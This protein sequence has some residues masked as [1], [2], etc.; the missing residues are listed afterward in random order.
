[1][2]KFRFLLA[3]SL[4]V[5][6]AF[7]AA[8]P[9]P[10]L[11]CGSAQVL[12]GV[13][14]TDRGKPSF[15]REWAWRPEHS[16][17][18]PLRLMSNFAGTDECKPVDDG[19]AILITSSGNALALVSRE[20][21]DTLFYATVRNAHSAALLPGGLIVAAAS[22]SSDGSGDR[23]LLFDRKAPDHAIDSFP[24]IG[25]HGVEWD[26]S[27]NVL[28][29]LSDRTLAQIT[30]GNSRKLASQ[31]TFTLPVRGGHDLVL[32]RDHSVLYLTTS[33]EVLTFDPVS[34][35]FSPFPP[36]QGISD[37]K[38]LSINPGTGQ[39]MYTQ[40]EPGVWW[41]YKL[42]FLHPNGEVLLAEHAYKARW[43]PEPR[44]R[45]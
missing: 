30:I 8:Q 13:I 35:K 14:K 43:L 44:G 7:A 29:A 40:A 17:G 24:F 6:S 12:E 20:S 19:R 25:A 16:S 9:M 26:S 42:K 2:N 21:G 3:V 41:T 28:W 4:S 37:V 27:R 1:M 10:L 22:Y 18:L 45:Q 23:L 38:S 5:G 34:G 36:F 31:R 11:I 15:V 32:A 33:K 39:I